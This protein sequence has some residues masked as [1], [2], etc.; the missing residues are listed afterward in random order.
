MREVL[1]ERAQQKLKA[2]QLLLSA[3]N[4]GYEGQ[5][6]NQG[7]ARP[8]NDWRFIQSWLTPEWLLH[9]SQDPSW[10]PERG[11]G[12]RLGVLVSTQI[13]VVIPATETAIAVWLKANSYTSGVEEV[14]EA[15]SVLETHYQSTI[16]S[17]DGRAKAQRLISQLRNM[18]GL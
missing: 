14:D 5:F 2:L 15:F 17:S 16:K 3:V 18:G 13:R 7:I 11:I 6:S 1:P 10:T 8:G 4:Q 9:M 12:I